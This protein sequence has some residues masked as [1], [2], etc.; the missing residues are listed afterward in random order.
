MIWT[1]FS[2]VTIA[3]GIEIVPLSVMSWMSLVVCDSTSTTAIASM[4]PAAVRLLCRAGTADE[5]A[6][7][8]NELGRDVLERLGVLP[9]ELLDRGADRR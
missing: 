5:V 7:L 1:T 8:V 3:S 4:S 9:G 6:R 2:S